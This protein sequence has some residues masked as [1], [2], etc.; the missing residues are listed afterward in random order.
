MFRIDDHGIVWVHY[1]YMIGGKIK[2]SE[3]LKISKHDEMCYS[4]ENFY[5]NEA[6]DM[7]C[8]LSPGIMKYRDLYNCKKQN[9]H[10]ERI[11]DE[12]EKIFGIIS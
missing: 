1:G 6:G 3:N 9:W 4:C 12:D 11:I 2:R 8:N 7:L 5:S 10:K